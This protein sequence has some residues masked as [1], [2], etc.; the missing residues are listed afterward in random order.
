[1]VRRL[2]QVVA[3]ATAVAVAIGAGTLVRHH[4]LEPDPVEVA[5]AATRA[6][7]S[8]D[9]EALRKVSL[10]PATVDCSAVTGVRD[11]YRSEGLEPDTFTYDVVAREDD[12]ASVRIRYERDD[13]PAEEIVELERLDDHWLVLPVPL[14]G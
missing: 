14:A 13:Q 6:Y 11:A 9:C 7:A 10:A 12:T 1:M 8:G 4:V 2:L 5:E 3:L